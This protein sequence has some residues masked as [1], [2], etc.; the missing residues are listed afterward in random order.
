M[1]PFG[2]NFSGEHVDR[3]SGQLDGGVRRAGPVPVWKRIRHAPPNEMPETRPNAG[4]SQC[5]PIPA[6]GAYSV[7]KASAHS[8]GSMPAKAAERVLMLSNAPGIGSAG[9]SWYDSNA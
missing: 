3:A 7:T 8:D 4:A 6:P 1:L 9:V 2:T 5:Q